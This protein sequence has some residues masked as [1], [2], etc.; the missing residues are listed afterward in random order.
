MYVSA[1]GPS[2][3]TSSQSSDPVEIEPWVFQAAFPTKV[4]DTFTSGM[5]QTALTDAPGFPWA[6]AVDS[7]TNGPAYQNFSDAVAVTY[8]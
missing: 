3:T 1:K 4:I 8:G 7:E 6:T 2:S 5:S